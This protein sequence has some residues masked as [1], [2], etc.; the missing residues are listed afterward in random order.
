VKRNKVK[1]GRQKG[2]YKISVM[3]SL[4]VGCCLLTYYFHAILGIGTIFTHFFYI[5]IILS[6][7]WWKKKGLPVAVLL[8]V[9]L[10][11]SSNFLKREM[12]NYND[13]PRAVMFISIA[14]VVAILSEMRTQ[15][16]EALQKA[17]DEL[18]IRVRRRTR[19]I[20][21]TNEKLLR[22]ITVRKLA[23]EQTRAA[24][25]EKEIL[26]KEIHHRVK[27]NFAIISS[28]IKL[29]ER[30]SKN[31]KSIK[32]LEDIHNR[33]RIMSLIHENLYQSKNIKSIDFGDYIRIVSSELYQ[34]YVSNPN[35]IVLKIDVESVQLTIEQAMPCGLALNEILTNSF[36]YAFPE[37]RGDIGEITISL[38]ETKDNL[39]EMVVG[40]NGVGIP[41]GIDIEGADTL[42]L[43]LVT[44]LTKQLGGEYA[45]DRNSGTKF[46]ITFQLDRGRESKL[47]RQG[48]LSKE[49]HTCELA[50]VTLSF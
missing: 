41:E 6:A 26:L 36:K 23:E 17:R 25:G 43:K 38:H 20:T 45:L 5:P 32:L 19:E 49:G 29:Q 35:K 30:G 11:L 13:Y 22:E 8:A 31:E 4:F 37:D 3:V 47:H 34:M 50:D 14:V 10:I 21:K 27:N 46:T 1:H 9:L 39:I 33:I 40:D 28:L 48:G 18:E 2:T 12:P 15:A 24:L 42:G 16:E 44:A 7:L